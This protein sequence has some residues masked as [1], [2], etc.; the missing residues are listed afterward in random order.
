MSSPTNQTSPTGDDQIPP[1]ELAAVLLGG[2]GLALTAGYV[3]SLVILLGAPPATH[4]TGTI[5]RM[6]SDLGMGDLIDAKIVAGLAIAFVLGAALSGVIIGSSTLRIGRRYGLTILIEALLLALAA[7][8]I[9]DSLIAGAMC[10]ACA[11]GLQNAMAASYRS[12][13]IRTTHVTGVLT[14][15]GFQLGQLL[16]GHKIAHWHFALLGLILVAFISGG[17]LG[18]LASTQL[19]PLALWLPAAWMGLTGVAYFAWRHLAARS[20]S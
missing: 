8:T 19:G 3:N 6:S 14:D 7:L 13:I 2:L 12:L 5:T 1:R 9:T 20:E 4:L 15:L 10:A 17:V 11:A 18:A 16:T